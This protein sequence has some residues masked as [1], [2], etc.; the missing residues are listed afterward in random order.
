MKG[1][2]KVATA[3]SVTDKATFAFAKYAITFD[4]RPLGEDPI[5][6]T[7]AAI[8]AGKL[9]SVASVNPNTGMILN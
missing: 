4:A 3:V 8:S 6:T 1:A 7:P 2:I 5:K 9:K